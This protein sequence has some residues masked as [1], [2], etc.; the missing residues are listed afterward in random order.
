[1]G[2]AAARSRS[3]FARD[4]AAASPGGARPAERIGAGIQRSFMVWPVALRGPL[5]ASLSNVQRYQLARSP[6]CD[7]PEVHSDCFGSAV[8]CRGA[9]PGLRGGRARV[10]LVLLPRILRKLL[11]KEP[12]PG[13]MPSPAAAL[14]RGLHSKATL[15]ARRVVGESS[16]H[17]ETTR[18]RR[19][20]LLAVAG[21][22]ARVT[23]TVALQMGTLC[24]RRSPILTIC[25]NHCER[26]QACIS[27]PPAE[28]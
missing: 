10:V 3:E 4:G 15:A 11:Q 27:R 7:L 21:E 20:S 23:K 28:T 22:L 5:P 13:Q 17:H 2:P 16:I 18:C 1:M 9:S 12:R 24:R 6:P 19:L 25:S 14:P 26:R 8:S